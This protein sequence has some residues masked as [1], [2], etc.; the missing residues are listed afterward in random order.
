METNW[1]TAMT[2]KRATAVHQPGLKKLE[3]MEL[4]TEAFRF[5]PKTE[6]VAKTAE[7]VIAPQTAMKIGNWNSMTRI[8]ENGLTPFFLYISICS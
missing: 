1:D 6:P 3:I 2:T 7:P 8:C 4:P 5:N